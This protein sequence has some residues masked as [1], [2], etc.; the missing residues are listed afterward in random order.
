LGKLEL[1]AKFLLAA[2]KAEDVCILQ[3]YPEESWRHQTPFSHRIGDG[4]VA[5]INWCQWWADESRAFST[6][7]VSFLTSVWPPAFPSFLS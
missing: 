1:F 4:E 2:G 5:P 7:K 3:N 6:S